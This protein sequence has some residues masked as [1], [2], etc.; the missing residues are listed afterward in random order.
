MNPFAY[1]GA[2]GV[3]IGFLAGWHFKPDRECPAALEKHHEEVKHAEVA[4]VAEAAKATTEVAPKVVTIIKRVPVQLPGV[5]CPVGVSE[6]IETTS[7]A[8][9]RVVQEA[10]KQAIA[11]IIQERV[12]DHEVVTAAAQPAWVAGLY[13]G[14][15]VGALVGGDRRTSVTAMLGHRFI[16]NLSIGVIA[17]WQRDAGVNVGIGGTIAW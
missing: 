4:A 1:L 9:S 12:I 15:N 6:T 11:T 2:A 5:G 13:V 16:G 8:D 14:A 7:T 10:S 17:Q 3:A